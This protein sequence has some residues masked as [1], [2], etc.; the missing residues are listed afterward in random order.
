MPEAPQAL[1]EQI[2]QRLDDIHDPCS[3]AGGM[4]LGLGEMGLVESVE[5][6]ASG[7]VEISLRLTS[8]FCEMI[9][10]MKTEAIARVEALDGVRSVEVTG[11]AGL[12][13]SPSMMSPDAQRRR[14]ARIDAVQLAAAGRRPR[15]PTA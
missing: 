1:R 7:D 9:A 15:V 2:L 12:D 5:I 13:W 14:R 11:D 6:S 3:V 10:F 8:P 4:P